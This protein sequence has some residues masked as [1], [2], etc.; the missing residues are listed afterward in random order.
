MSPVTHV[1]NTYTGVNPYL[2]VYYQPQSASIVYSYVQ[3]AYNTSPTL[4]TKYSSM[5]TIYFDP[6]GTISIKLGYSMMKDQLIVLYHNPNQANMYT[7]SLIRSV[8]VFLYYYETSEPLSLSY[9]LIVNTSATAPCPSNCSNRG[10][11][12]S[13][14]DCQC[15]TGYY[16]YDCS[17]DPD[18]LGIG[19]NV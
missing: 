10:S 8:T 3:V 11:C 9:D 1:L 19:K 14:G 2:C 17:V 4:P 7:C 13:N 18:I 16:G 15:Q 6:Y 5:T 12:L